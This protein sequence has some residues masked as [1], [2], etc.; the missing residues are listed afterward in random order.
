M[1]QPLTFRERQIVAR[2]LYGYSNQRTAEELSLSVQT[3]RVHL[4]SV[5]KKLQVSGPFK[6]QQLAVMFFGKKEEE[7]RAA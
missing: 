6:R 2:I 4:K 1:T 7:K 3:V 5:Y